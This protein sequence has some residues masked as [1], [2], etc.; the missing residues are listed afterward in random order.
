VPSTDHAL[1]LPALRDL[2]A[3]AD[4]LPTVA[5]D[6]REQLP[7]P[8]TRLKSTTATLYSGDYSV[9]GA[10]RQVAIERKSIEDLVACTMGENRER[11]ERELTRM[12]GYYFRR[13][14][15]VGT[16]E[17]LEAGLYHSNVNPKAVLASLSAW[18]VRFNVPVVFSATPQEAGRQVESWCYWIA[19]Q[20][21]ANANDLLRGCRS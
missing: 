2:G 19:R 3:L 15:I 9:I 10:E 17:V 13:L 12:G 20:I 1:K 14:L 11:F 18:E 4:H 21:V 16:R 8:I 6:S 7:L 5:I